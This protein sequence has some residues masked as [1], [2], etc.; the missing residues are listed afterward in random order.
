[1]GLDRISNLRG[2]MKRMAV[3]IR[4]SGA[5]ACVIALGAGLTALHAQEPSSA[6]KKLKT[7]ISDAQNLQRVFADG[8]QHCDALNGTSYYNA[9]QKRVVILSELKASMQNLIN[10]QVFNAPKSHLWSK[11]D[12]DERMK[13][14]QS[15]ADKDKYNC[16]L[17]AKLPEMIK[18]LAALESKQ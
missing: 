10:D 6:A 4:R 13:T 18:G 15:Q 3:K 8:L 2:V 5:V 11:E 7:D 14:A 12:S 1:V 16:N 17:V 9:T